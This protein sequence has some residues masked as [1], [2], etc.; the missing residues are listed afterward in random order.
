MVTSKIQK[1]P[2]IWPLLNIRVIDGDTIEGDI[3][4]PFDQRIRKRI[5][6]KGWWADELGGLWAEAANTAKVRLHCFCSNRALWLHSPNGRLDKYGRVIGTLMEGERIVTAKE[7][8]GELQLTE[9]VH[10]ARTDQNRAK[11]RRSG[12]GDPPEVQERLPGPDSTGSAMEPAGP[13]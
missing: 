9:S 11:R 3:L 1:T 4:F 7:V 10:K 12:L 6:L 8:L 2:D 13:L 5:R